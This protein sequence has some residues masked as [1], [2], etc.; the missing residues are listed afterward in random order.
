MLMNII[1][2]VC[3]YVCAHTIIHI[4][5][6]VYTAGMLCFPDSL[7]QMVSSSCVDRPRR[8]RAVHS[9]DANDLTD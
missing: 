5:H 6:L 7:N 8:R 2:P 3:P 1:F 4:L 9:I